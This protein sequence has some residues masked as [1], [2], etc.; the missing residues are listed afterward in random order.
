MAIQSRR[1]CAG[2]D[3]GGVPRFRWVWCC[4]VGY[5]NTMR[6]WCGVV[7]LVS[8]GVG[9]AGVVLRCLGLVCFFPWGGWGRQDV[10]HGQCACGGSVW[11]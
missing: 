6:T 4:L 5:Y 8:S 1:S 9:G 11:A 7:G 2:S 3:I 10:S